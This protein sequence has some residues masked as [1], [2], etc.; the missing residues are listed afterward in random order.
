MQTTS[1]THEYHT[2]TSTYSCP[3]QS[4]NYHNPPTPSITYLN[5][6]GISIGIRLLDLTE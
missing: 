6:T 2:S 5:L 4:H 3:P 1:T